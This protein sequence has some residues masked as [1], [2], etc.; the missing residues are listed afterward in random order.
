MGFWNRLIGTSGAERI[1]D[2]RAAGSPSPR[3]R[4]ATDMHEELCCDPRVAAQ[5][6][7][8]ATDNAAELGLVP[9]REIT[10]DDIDLDFYNGP[11]GFRLEHL[12]AL[13]RL[14]EDDGTPLYPKTVHFD[15]ECVNSNDAYS[16]LVWQVADAAGTTERFA[17]VRC[18]LH[19]G[20][21]FAKFPVGELH[22][23]LDGEPVHHDVAVE[24]EWAD[25]EVVRRIFQDAT[26]EGHRWV[27]TGDFAVHVW[28][29]EEHADNIARIFASEDTAAEAR[30]AGR[31]YEERHHGPHRHHPDPAGAVHEEQEEAAQQGEEGHRD[32]PDHRRDGQ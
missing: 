1:V 10:V 14:T 7:L 22:Y 17:D 15:P 4:R 2:A 8:L 5:A 32:G 31:F 20:P 6:L 21:N 29:P 27:A 12:S 3:H 30:L 24:G 25:P 9:N 28:V 18:D 13:L 26:P 23:R 16:R 11:D 19:F